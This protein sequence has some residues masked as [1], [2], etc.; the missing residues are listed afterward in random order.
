MNS[1]KMIIRLFLSVVGGFLL[2][3]ALFWLIVKVT[4]PPATHQDSPVSQTTQ[5]SGD[6]L[7]PP[8]KINFERHSEITLCLD[9]SDNLEEKRACVSQEKTEKNPEHQ[10]DSQENISN[11]IDTEQ[12]QTCFIPYLCFLSNQLFI[13]L[14][15][16]LQFIALWTQASV[17]LY[18]LI[19]LYLKVSDNKIKNVLGSV[20]RWAIDSPPVI[21]VV[22]T[23]YA[24]SYAANQ[25]TADGVASKQLTEVFKAAFNDAVLTTMIGGIIYVINLALNIIKDSNVEV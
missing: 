11:N 8:Q 5:G 19:G 12:S 22:G 17:I 15:Y 21:G 13:Q 7:Y 4:L 20:S 23:L 18:V 25:A 10:T 24:F 14:I 2:A 1:I 6:N 9:Q 3:M 16:L